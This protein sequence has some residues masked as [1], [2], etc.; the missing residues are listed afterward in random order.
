MLTG[1]CAG[2]SSAATGRAGDAAVSGT[3]SATWAAA[4]SVATTSACAVCSVCATSP[5]RTGVSA[6]TG[7]TPASSGRRS[8]RPPRRPRRARL[9]S[10]AGASPPATAGV[11]AATGST[12]CWRGGRGGRGSLGSLGSFA[13]RGSRCSFASPAGRSFSPRPRLGSL[14]LSGFSAFSLFS[15][16]AGASLLGGRSF[17]P[18]WRGLLPLPPR[19]ASPRVSGRASRRGG[20]SAVNTAGVGSALLSEN[21]ETIVLQ[22]LRGLA[23]GNCAGASL[24]LGSTIGAGWPSAMP[25]TAASW[26]A[27]F[28]S[29]CAEGV[30]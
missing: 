9:P 4:V 6:A 26:R 18:P 7:V 2:T 27:G 13:S 17:R 23:A 11:S 30:M 20:R 19:R 22:R 29:V 21:Q 14:W 28:A 8:R 15:G 5:T 3:K 1:S 16:C 25:L 12:V 24:T 10:S